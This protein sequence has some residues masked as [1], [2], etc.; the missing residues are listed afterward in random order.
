MQFALVKADIIIF[1]KDR[2]VVEC[3]VIKKNLNQRMVRNS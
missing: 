1:Y 2:L 3:I